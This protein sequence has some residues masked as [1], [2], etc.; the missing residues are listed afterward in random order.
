MSNRYFEILQHV[1]SSLVSA[2]HSYDEAALLSPSL[3]IVHEAHFYVARLAASKI[4]LCGIGTWW[5][6][7]IL[8][9]CKVL[10]CTQITGIDDINHHRRRTVLMHHEPSGIWAI[11]PG[12]AR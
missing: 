2:S 8:E 5:T 12:P 9:I 4:L 1:E 3:S 6:D 11:P 7:T 10:G